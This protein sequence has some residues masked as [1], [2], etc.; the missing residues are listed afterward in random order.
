MSRAYDSSVQ[1]RD[2]NGKIVVK[3]SVA[4]TVN[5]DLSSMTVCG[6]N[7]ISIFVPQGAIKGQVEGHFIVGD[8]NSTGVA[9]IKAKMNQANGH[10]RQ[11]DTAINADSARRERGLKMA[12]QVEAERVAQQVMYDQLNPDAKAERNIQAEIIRQARLARFA[13]TVPTVPA[14]T[15]A[16][17]VNSP[18]NLICAKKT[19]PF[20]LLSEKDVCKSIQ[21]IC[22]DLQF[23]VEVDNLKIPA[24][25]TLGYLLAHTTPESVIRIVSDLSEIPKPSVELLAFLRKFSPIH[26]N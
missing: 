7:G 15:I 4:T 1:D 19:I 16:S 22:E 9:D 23:H 6:P 17:L 25:Y 24:T 14:V 10:S 2:Q 18:R 5:N 13:P 20:C 21:S 26:A 11:R 12:Q 8:M 3:K